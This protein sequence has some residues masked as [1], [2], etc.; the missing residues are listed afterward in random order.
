M[1]WSGKGRTSLVVFWCISVCGLHSMMGQVTNPV[2]DRKS[3]NAEVEISLNKTTVRVG[4]T[5]LITFKITNRGSIPFYIPKTIQDVDFRGGFQALV[6]GPPQA[7]WRSTGGA[8]DNF[9]PV[10]V[11]KEIE[12]SWILLSPGDFYGG[13]RPLN[14]VPLSPGTYKVVGRRNPPRLS[15]DLKEKI[16]SGLK[17]LVL[18]DDIESTPLYFRVE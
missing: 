14:T 9:G 2:N 18:L 12:E 6:S 11:A 8:A 15:E 17:F 10:D 4:E 3:L 5:P 13:T 1:R 16:R 7:K